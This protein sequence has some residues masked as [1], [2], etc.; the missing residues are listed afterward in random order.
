[1][2]LSLD[3]RI[4]PSLDPRMEL[5]P[6]TELDLR[7]EPSLDLRVEQE[8]GKACHVPRAP[9]TQTLRGLQVPWC[10]CALRTGDDAPPPGLSHALWLPSRPDAQEKL[11]GSSPSWCLHVSSL[12][13]L[14]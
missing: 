11:T 6:R 12:L 10:Q 13:S 9:P 2:E 14:F 7:I 3:P 4:E 8:R 5:D 1:M